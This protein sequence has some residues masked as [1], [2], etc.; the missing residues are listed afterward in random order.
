MRG[1][2]PPVASRRLEQDLHGPDDGHNRQYDDGEAGNRHRDAN[3]Y[4]QQKVTDNQQD[5]D[6]DDRA[7]EGT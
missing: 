4:V 5:Q 1:P 6:R 7:T 2:R 3:Q